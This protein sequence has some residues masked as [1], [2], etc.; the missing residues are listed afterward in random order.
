MSDLLNQLLC[1]FNQQHDDDTRH[2]LLKNEQSS[3]S[4]SPQASYQ[5]NDSPSSPVLSP[6][7]ITSSSSSKI[8]RRR[9][10]LDSLS[11]HDIDSSDRNLISA[12]I[13]SVGVSTYV[14]LPSEMGDDD[15]DT[16]MT[17]EHDEVGRRNL[18]EVDDQ[19][20]VKQKQIEEEEQLKRKQEE[21][22]REK[23]V[24]E[25]RKKQEEEKRKKEEQIRLQK[26]K[27]EA[28][29]KKQEEEKRKKEE[30]IRVQ[31]EKEEAAKKEA[32][33]LEQEKK[34]KDELLKK[35]QE[36]QKKKEEQ[37]RKQKEEEENR[38]QKEEAQRIEK[39]KKAEEL[40]K[41]QEEEKLK[42]EE[43]IRLQKEKEETE[44]IEKEKKAEELRK[45]QEE[46]KRQ[47]E[48]QIR[49]QK[50]K[51]EAAKKEAARLEQEK[52]QKETQ[53]LKQVQEEKERQAKNQKLARKATATSDNLI[54]QRLVKHDK[55]RLAVAQ[56][57]RI[58]SERKRPQTDISDLKKIDEL[59]STYRVDLPDPN[60]VTIEAPL[61][62]SA[63]STTTSGR[64]QTP[65]QFVP[66]KKLLEDRAK[67]NPLMADLSKALSSRGGNASPI[68][69]PTTEQESPTEQQP[70]KPQ[71][72]STS[73]PTTKKKV[74]LSDDE[75]VRQEKELQQWIEQ[76]VSDFNFNPDESFY[77]NLSNGTVLCKL[78]NQLYPD[79]IDMKKVKLEVKFPF[80]AHSNVAVFLSSCESIGLG[81]DNVFSSQDLKEETNKNAV[82]GYL[83]ELKSKSG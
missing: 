42:K 5:S 6:S 40:R 21:V 69:K 15:L 16:N 19:Y 60:L 53:R 27:E 66:P 62:T 31:K 13:A 18:I 23:K 37:L 55:E 75:R 10:E 64:E 77:K 71:L 8:P 43:Q 7:S 24:E 1:C 74:T 12:D 30:Q 81:K 44:R 79:S 3:T 49:V 11:T 48:E 82:V 20:N 59:S 65:T 68:K 67:S 45:K 22:E 36:E 33:R 4:V 26:E 17:Y 63:P 76:K 70:V 73:S 39:E 47:K 2:Q 29:R 61:Q 54:A 25:H 80:H 51:E 56:R 34:Q 38:K 57:P 9:N 41:K 32:A 58:A 50:E 46:E 52:K 28:E 35:Q 83:S 78:M 72:R 14:D